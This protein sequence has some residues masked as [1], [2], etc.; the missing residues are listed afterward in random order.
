MPNASLRTRI[1]V[2]DDEPALLR[3]LEQYLVRSGHEVETC[4]SASRA[5]EL[6]GDDPAAY[7]LVVADLRMP[8]MSGEELLEKLM[9][10]NPSIRIVVC[11]GYP[12]EHLERRPGIER[13]IRFVQKPFLPRMLDQ[14]IRELIDSV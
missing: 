9:Q 8:G 14:A 4:G 12:F 6:Y 5:L 2:V 1:L 11:S 7:S 10:R 3:L 13:Q